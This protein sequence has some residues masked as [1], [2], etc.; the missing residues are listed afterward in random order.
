MN[1]LRQVQRGIDFIEQNLDSDVAIADVA[2]HAGISQWHFQRIFKA[3][4]NETLKTYIRSRRFANALVKLSDGNA[5]ILD[6]AFEAGFES[7]ESFTRA[8]KKAFGVTPAYYRRRRS[9]LPFLRK[10]RFDEDYLRHI[11]RGVTLEPVFSE[12]PPRTFVGMRTLFYG[13]D[14]EKNNLAT[15]LP[16]LWAAFVPRLDEIRRLHRGVAYGVI[17][18]TAAQ[19]EELEYF[20]AVEVTDR[21]QVPDGMTAIELPAARYAAFTHTGNL[22]RLDATVSYIYSSWLARSGMRHTYGP[23]LEVYDGR[24]RPDSEESEVEYA[25]PVVGEVL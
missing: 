25:I 21:D 13:V 23:D 20:A 12:H 3:L 2:R 14:S 24:Y 17:R 22:S 18:Q 16:S 15:K 8:F 11:H 9:E 19:G 4:T 10:L 7:Q 6:I 5:R 1:Y